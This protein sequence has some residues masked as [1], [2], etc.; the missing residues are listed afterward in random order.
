MSVVGHGPKE[1][2]AWIP[3]VSLILSCAIKIPLTAQPIVIN[4]DGAWCWFQDEQ[5]VICEGKLMVGS[6][7]NGSHD[8]RRHG[9]IDVTTVDLAS[10]RS[11]RQ[12]LFGQLENDDHDVPALWVRPDGRVQAVFAKHG[13][14]SHFYYGTS[15][16]SWTDW[17]RVKKFTPRNSSRITYANLLFL[18]AEN[19]GRGRLYNFYR[20]LDASFKPSYAWSDDL[21]TTWQSGHVVIDVPVAFRHRPY[22]KYASNGRDTIHLLYTDGHPH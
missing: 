17:G 12:N 5:A 11:N 3:L 4:D 6:V 16:V 19:D 15:N 2:N 13:S 18:S 10:G 1:R 22:V 7:A 8:V 20:G 9:D 21:G 14:E